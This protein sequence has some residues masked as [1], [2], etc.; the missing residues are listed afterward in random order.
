M[1]CFLMT[2]KYTWV[3]LPPP[4]PIKEIN[5]VIQLLAEGD[6]NFLKD[7]HSKVSVF[8][9][10]IKTEGSQVLY[11]CMDSQFEAMQA[12]ALRSK[13][14]LYKW[15]SINKKWIIDVKKTTV[16]PDSVRR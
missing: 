13:I 7:F 3:R 11:S 4:P 12:A 1:W 16:K 5:M 10:K 6:S 2:L 8:S 14:N 9:S 15:D